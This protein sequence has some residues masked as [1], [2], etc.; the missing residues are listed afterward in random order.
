[1][2]IRESSLNLAISYHPKRGTIVCANFDQGFRQPEMTKR[3]LCVVISPPIQQR[4]GICTVVPLSTTEPHKEMS[5][6]YE[7]NIPFQLPKSWGNRSRWVKADMVCAIGWHRIDLLR[8]G[9][10]VN[11]ARQYQLLTL[12]NVHLENISKCVLN[13]LGLSALTEHI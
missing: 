10:D 9:K 4:V 7:L 8:L 5:Y 1:M 2:N 3:R 13:S 11:G 12:S 6:H